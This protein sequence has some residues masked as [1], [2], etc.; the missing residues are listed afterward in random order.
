MNS[1]VVKQKMDQSYRVSIRARVLL[2]YLFVSMSSGLLYSSY[3]NAQSL[4]ADDEEA[5]F[6]LYGDEDMISVATGMRQSIAKAPAVATVITAQDILTMGATDLDEVL[7]TVPGLHV[8]RNNFGYAPIYTVRGIYSNYSPQVLVLI[9]GIPITNLY[10]GDRNLI[11]GGM[12]VRA[13]ARIEVI[14]GPG[15]AIYGAEAFAG[16]I[17]IITKSPDDIEQTTVGVR[18]GS[19]NTKDGWIL[20]SDSWGETDVALTLEYHKTDGQDEKIDADA[21][22]ELD[23]AFGTDASLAPGPVNLS[24]ENLDVRFDATYQDLR[25]R[26]GLQRRRDFGN[27]AGVAEALD[28]HNRYASDRRNFDLTYHNAT[29]AQDWDL[30]VQLSYLDTSQE[31]EE[32]LIIYPSGVNILGEVFPNGMVGNPE[33]YE[34]HSRLNVSTFFTGFE[35]H[36]LRFGAGYYLGE[37]YKVKECKNFRIDPLTGF[38]IA[39]GGELVDVSG[40]PSVFLEEGDRQNRYAFVQD[41]WGFIEDWELTWG[42]RYD[43]FSDFGD[44][45]NPRAALVWSTRHDLTM[46]LLYGR[47]F[48]SPSYAELLIKNNPAIIGNPDLD[49]EEIDSLELAFDYRP[50]ERVRLGLNIFAYRWKDIIQYVANVGAIG[51]TA[52]NSGKQYGKGFEM[53]L[54]WQVTGEL[55]ISGNFS[56]QD[57]EERPEDGTAKSDAANAPQQQ[58]YLAA[59]WRFLEIWSVQ[60]QVN[61][62]LDRARAEVDSRSAVDDYAVMDLTLRRISNNGN[63]GAA[64]SIRNLFDS[65]AREPSLATG[66]IPDD[67][68]LSGRSIYAELDVRF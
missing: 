62:V 55:D 10:N 8:A 53:E 68:P 3:S 1:C 18:T 67:L 63:W 59:K 25:F 64:V 12:P 41:Q 15:S 56:Y 28:Q 11:W 36:Q 54:N 23:A 50:V 29:L 42:V 45:F 43:D 32:D 47:A 34:R 44:T 37:I 52:Q 66:S 60:S 26:A 46:K 9:N 5:L 19:F 49:P 13:I 7:E 27:G 40:S 17:S 6:E 61:Y 35:R 48:R 16:V 24:R 38:P 30:T 22:T 51:S 20:A 31:V 21:Q 4:D 2:M 58:L 65:D 14:R 39:L 57:S 33:V